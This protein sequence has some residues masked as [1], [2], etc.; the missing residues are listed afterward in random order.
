MKNS[1]ER[2]NQETVRLD[3]WKEAKGL[4]ELHLLLEPDSGQTVAR[5]YRSLVEF[6][7]QSCDI[8]IREPR[9][10]LLHRKAN[11]DT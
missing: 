8:S 5:V 6:E 7:K 4:S 3:L 2:S 10:T 11:Q 9:K 1:L